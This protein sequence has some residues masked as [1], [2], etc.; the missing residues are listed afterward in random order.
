MLLGAGLGLLYEFLRP[1]RPK[2][3]A[4][5]DLIFSLAAIWAAAKLGF[6]SVEYEL[7]EL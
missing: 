6:G 5:A 3:T 2:R 7:I 1:L 4:A